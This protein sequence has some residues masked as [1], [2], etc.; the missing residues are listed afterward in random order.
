MT[1]RR[2]RERGIALLLALLVLVILA[3]VVVQM[4]V[5]S[6]HTKTVAENHLADLQNTYGV[7]AGYHQAVLFL[8][9]DFEQGADVDSLGERWAQPIDFDLGLAHVQVSIQDT[10]RSISLSQLVNDQG[11][12]NPVVVGQLR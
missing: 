9:S 1:R 4:T 5:S 7:R 8:R 6:L 12:A 10:E 3:V 2:G 11:E